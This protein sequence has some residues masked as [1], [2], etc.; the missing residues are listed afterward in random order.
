MEVFV[1]DEI[2]HAV[3]MYGKVS[4]QT[5]KLDHVGD[6]ITEERVIVKFAAKLLTDSDEFKFDSAV[7]YLN[8]R[9]FS[10]RPVDRGMLKTSEFILDLTWNIEFDYDILDFTK[11]KKKWGIELIE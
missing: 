1:P 5:V 3:L 2:A 10:T 11:V 9:V 4:V 7:L 8:G 6:E